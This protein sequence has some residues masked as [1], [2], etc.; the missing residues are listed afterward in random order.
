VLF[1]SITFWENPATQRSVWKLPGKPYDASSTKH[2]KV[3]VAL[4]Q[5]LWGS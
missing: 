4:M 1:V 2:R 5:K 3:F